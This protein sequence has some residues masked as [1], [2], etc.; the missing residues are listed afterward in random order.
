MFFFKLIGS[1]PTCR[2]CG[3]D[4]I[5]S[6]VFGLCSLLIPAGYSNDSYYYQVV[7]WKSDL[8]TPDIRTIRYKNLFLAFWGT[9]LP[10]KL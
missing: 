7:Q 4:L 5:R 8:R 10:F 1:T 2:Y 3:Q 9:H 6:I